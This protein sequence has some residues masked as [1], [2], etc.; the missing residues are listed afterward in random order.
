MSIDTG[1]GGNLFA[2]NYFTMNGSHL[3]GELN[4]ISTDFDLLKN[5]KGNYII[6]IRPKNVSDVKADIKKES[7]GTNEEL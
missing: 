7:K 2:G 3:R 6:N 1:M 4:K 5:K